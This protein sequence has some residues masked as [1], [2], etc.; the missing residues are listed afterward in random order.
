MKCLKFLTVSTTPISF[1]YH[2]SHFCKLLSE[3]IRNPKWFVNIFFPD[4]C[5]TDW[6]FEQW[7]PITNAL[8]TVNLN[9]HHFSIFSKFNRSSATVLNKVMSMQIYMLYKVKQFFTQKVCAVYLISIMYSVFCIYVYCTIFLHIC[10]MR[11]Y[12]FS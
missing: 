5:L 4:A 7:L 6:N 10:I 12:F 9:K 1:S 11:T 2:F 3:I 8:Q